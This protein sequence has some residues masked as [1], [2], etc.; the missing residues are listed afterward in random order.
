MA[1]L[2]EGTM[3]RQRLRSQEPQNPVQKRTNSEDN[4]YLAVLRASEGKKGSEPHCLS[5]GAGLPADW[6]AAGRGRE[7]RK[8][9][10]LWGHPR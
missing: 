2:G 10:E 6:L 8:G 7:V 1:P 4:L 3:S 9:A 5:L